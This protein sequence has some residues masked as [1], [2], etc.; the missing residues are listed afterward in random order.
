MCVC[1]SYD[2]PKY[3]KC[4]KAGV[5][6]P[7][8]HSARSYA[9]CSSGIANENGVYTETLCGERGGYKMYKPVRKKKKNEI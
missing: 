1:C 4:Q 3:E 7:G 2:C 5:N 9:T 6:N 8:V